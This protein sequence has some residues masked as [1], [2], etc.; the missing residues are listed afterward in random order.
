[1]AYFG[2]TGHCLPVAHCAT[3]KW[4]GDLD[5]TRVFN[6]D[7]RRPNCFVANTIPLEV[8]HSENA[9]AKNGPQLLFV[10]A[11]FLKVTLTG[12]VVQGPLRIFAKHG[13]FADGR[14]K[15]RA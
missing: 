13:N 7:L 5:E 12:L 8:R 11:A 6:E 2:S 1:M 15:M 9:R 4:I 14:T 10:V 3:H